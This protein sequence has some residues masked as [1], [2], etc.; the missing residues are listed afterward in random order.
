VRTIIISVLTNDVSDQFL[1]EGST[2]FT[3]LITAVWYVWPS[4]N[5]RRWLTRWNG[6][7]YNLIKDTNI[8]DDFKITRLE[9]AGLIIRMDDER[10]PRKFS[11]KTKNKMEGRRPEEHVIS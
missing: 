5:K 7:I 8:V 3:S 2:A 11:E 4:T 6:E 1:K 9:W 10:I